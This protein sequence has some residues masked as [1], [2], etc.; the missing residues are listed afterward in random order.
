[1]LMTTLA[2]IITAGEEENPQPPP[3]SQPIEIQPTEIQPTS[4][5]TFIPGALLPTVPGTG[6]DVGFSAD[7]PVPRGMALP[8]FG[9]VLAVTEVISPA[10]DMVL[11]ASPQNPP[12]PAG[13]QYLLVRVYIDCFVEQDEQYPDYCGLTENLAFQLLAPDGAAYPPILDLVNL[14]NPYDPAVFLRG[15][16]SDAYLA[17]IIPATSHDLVLMITKY[18][19]GEMYFALE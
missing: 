7:N 18:M 5:P 12:P 3:V 16:A 19:V 9:E 6:W 4:R 1:M 15:E 10:T 2:C 11:A 14:P 8:L 13:S 17:F